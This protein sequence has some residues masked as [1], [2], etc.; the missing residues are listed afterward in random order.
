MVC[1]ALLA[2]AFATFVMLI[3]YDVITE[4]KHEVIGVLKIFTTQ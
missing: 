2:T 3:R 4:N 1:F